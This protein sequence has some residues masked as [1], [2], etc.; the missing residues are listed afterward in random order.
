MPQQQDFR[1]YVEKRLSEGAS[2]DQIKAEL[3]D[4]MRKQQT[5]RAASGSVI[6]RAAMAESAIKPATA[7]SP[8]VENAFNFPGQIGSAVKTFGGDIGGFLRNLVTGPQSVE[9]AQQQAAS[10]T[11]PIQV[12]RMIRGLIGAEA[13]AGKQTYGALTA[14]EGVNVGDL[15]GAGVK[16]VT[17]GLIG[18]EPQREF[19]EGNWG[20]AAGHIATMLAGGR[21]GGGKGAVGG[22]VRKVP[23]IGKVAQKI[24][25]L[26]R[27]IQEPAAIAAERATKVAETAKSTAITEAEQIYTLAKQGGDVA[28]MKEQLKVLADNGLSKVELYKRELNDIK[29]LEPTQPVKVTKAPGGPQVVTTKARTTPDEVLRASK[30]SSVPDIE[31]GAPEA[32]PTGSRDYFHAN[33]STLGAWAKGGDVKAAAE[34]ARR[35]EGKPAKGTG[36]GYLTTEEVGKAEPTKI[37]G[38]KDFVIKSAQ[39]VFDGA[40]KGDV[41]AIAEIERRTKNALAEGSAPAVIIMETNS[42]SFVS[43]LRKLKIEELQGFMKNDRIPELSKQVIQKLIDKKAKAPMP[44]LEST[45]SAA[46]PAATTTEAAT[47]ATSQLGELAKIDFEKFT[48][49][50]Q[51]LI[52]KGVKAGKPIKQVLAELEG[53]AGGTQPPPFK[54]TE[55]A[56]KSYPPSPTEGTRGPKS[57]EWTAAVEFLRTPRGKQLFRLKEQVSEIKGRKG[58]LLPEDIDLSILD[59]LT[60]KEAKYLDFQ[61]AKHFREKVTEFLPK[62]D[63]RVSGIPPE[64]KARFIKE[65]PKF[66]SMSPQQLAAWIDMNEGD[67]LI[68][69]AE[70]VLNRKRPSGKGHSQRA[71]LDTIMGAQLASKSLATEVRAYLKNRPRTTISDLQRVFPGTTELEL[72]SI[73]ESTPGI[74]L[75][76]APKQAKELPTIEVPEEPPA[77]PSGPRSLE[78][79]AEEE[80]SLRA[81]LAAAKSSELKGRI[82]NRLSRL[83]KER[84]SIKEGKPSDIKVLD[85]LERQ[86][87]TNAGIAKLK[88][89]SEENAARDKIRTKFVRAIE[90]AAKAIRVDSGMK[91]NP[92]AIRNAEATLDAAHKAMVEAG[93]T[94]KEIVATYPPEAMATLSKSGFKGAPKNPE[95]S[96]DAFRS[97]ATELASNEMA[98][99]AGASVA[100]LSQSRTAFKEALDNLRRS[101]GYSLAEIEQLV[102]GKVFKEIKRYLR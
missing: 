52:I 42:P 95:V 93:F 41:K 73:A 28:K 79:I 21:L 58:E 75:V 20:P 51:L 37:K 29:P 54:A 23:I 97:A 17:G 46:Q 4:M 88:R 87:E 40:T 14:P 69:L 13:E 35:A 59:K 30:Q 16:A 8:V 9:E 57:P 7:V 78:V 49:E 55:E 101:T 99:A 25:L 50:Q 74:K 43:G 94:P 6:E 76:K 84:E 32:T 3:K 68:A 83:R 18:D 91:K 33:K 62:L 2:D 15:T 72:R 82:A 96:V 61:N 38:E 34:Q 53:S 63:S 80:S 22:A 89:T 90:D 26:K 36:K 66:N 86:A 48:P 71:P 45:P 5:G 60:D 70:H 65:A 64:T 19:L 77:K 92:A 39:D 24:P 27:A 67:P 1:A 56:P 85:H 10:P 12:Q 31:P 98:N 102:S 47:T 44:T 100:K 81:E 11:V